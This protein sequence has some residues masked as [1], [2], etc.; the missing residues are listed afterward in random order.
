MS[1]H[2]PS[3]GLLMFRLRDRA[4]EVLLGH[5]GGPYFQHQDDGVWSIPKGEREPDEDLLAAALREFHEEV[6]LNASGPF[7]KLTPV[8]QSSQKIVHAWAFEGDCDPK[9]CVS[10]L[11]QMEWPPKSGHSM[12]FPEFDHVDFFDLAAARQKIVPGQVPLI[13]ELERILQTRAAKSSE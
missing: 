10:N 9:H 1:S 5:P 6:G 2:R 7:I 13:D 8:K 11:F 3:T 4:P 12:E